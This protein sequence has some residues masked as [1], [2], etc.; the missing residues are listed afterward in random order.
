VWPEPDLVVGDPNHPV[1]GLDELV[2][3]TTVG[4]S[5]ELGAVVD[6]TDAARRATA[7]RDA[8]SDRA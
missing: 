5:I 2:V 8:P 1:S 3:A 4:L 6:S 7:A